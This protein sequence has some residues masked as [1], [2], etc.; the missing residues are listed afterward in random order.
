[1]MTSDVVVDFNVLIAFMEDIVINNVNKHCDYH[2][3]GEFQWV[4]EHLSQLGAI[5]ARRTQ[6]WC[7]QGHGTRNN[8]ML[9]ATS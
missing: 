8:I 6:Q 4:M 2:N 9:L 7:Q 3:I 5:E 1:M